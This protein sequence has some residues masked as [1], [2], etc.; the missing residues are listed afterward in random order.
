MLWWIKV[1]VQGEVDFGVVCLLKPDPSYGTILC[2]Y[3]HLS[4]K[5]IFFSLLGFH[6]FFTFLKLQRIQNLL[7]S[8]TTETVSGNKSM[9]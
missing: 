8:D 2:F 9:I 3:S 1:S 5:L 4:R 7:Q 6:V